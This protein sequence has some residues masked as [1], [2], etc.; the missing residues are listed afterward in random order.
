MSQTQ[1]DGQTRSGYRKRREPLIAALLVILGLAV[2]LAAA[3]EWN[4]HHPN[5]PERLRYG[6]EPSYDAPARAI[7]EGTWFEQPDRLPLYPMWLAFWHAVTGVNYDAVVYAQCL[8]GAAGVLL[9]WL[10]AR[11]VADVTTATLAAAAVAVSPV[12]VQQVQHFIP[13]VMF[14]VVLVLLALLLVRAWQQPATARF[15]VAGACVGVA[16]LIRPTFLF[17]PV[18][19]AAAVLITAR[20]SRAAWR[21]ALAYALAAYVVTAPWT[22]RN[23]VVHDTFLPLSTSNATLWLGSPEYHH[24]IHDQGYTYRRVWDE[25]IYPDDPAVPYPTTIEGE[26]YWSERGMRSIR[27]EP[28]LYARLVAERLGTYWVGDPVVDWGGGPPLNFGYLRRHM[29]PADALV[30]LA[31]RAL[32]L[33]AAVAIV[34]LWRRRRELLALYV[35]LLYATLLHAATVARVRMSD[36]FRPIL[37][38]LVAAAAVELGRAWLRRMRHGRAAAT[39]NALTEAPG[40]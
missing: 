6:D 3:V 12:L 2:R 8:L 1:D 34:V 16:N 37:L 21:H 35:I 5:G 22:I 13:E 29:S 20:G 14:T 7:L 32:P 30:R 26:Q 28:L 23:Y 31:E 39:P 15:A 33:L 19:V 27:S 4:A 25:I 9:T 11:R 17:L 36:P 10:L 24:L 40:A 18:F 38:V